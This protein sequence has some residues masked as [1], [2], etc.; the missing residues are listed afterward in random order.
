MRINLK[1]PYISYY[2]SSGLRHL[3]F[4]SSRRVPGTA[5]LRPHGSARNQL[6]FPRRGVSCFARSD[7]RAAKSGTRIQVYEL[8]LVLYFSGYVSHFG[9]YEKKKLGFCPKIPNTLLGEALSP[10]K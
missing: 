6:A 5:T 8:V 2:A 9:F 10:I 1:K 7:S 4:R 3:G